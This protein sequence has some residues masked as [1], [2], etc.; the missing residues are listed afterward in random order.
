MK[1]YGAKKATEFTKK[2]I[3]VIYANAK[4][5]NLTIEKWA[6]QNLYDLADYFGYDDNRSVEREEEVIK[7]IL[8]SVFNNDFEAAQKMIFELQD[9]WYNWAGNKTKASYDRSIFVK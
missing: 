5:G 7:M 6:M 4:N 9:N 1:Q 2:Q 8:E 3:N